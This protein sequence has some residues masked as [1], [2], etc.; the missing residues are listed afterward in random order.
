MFRRL[1]SLSTENPGESRIHPSKHPEATVSPRPD[2]AESEATARATSPVASGQFA[3]TPLELAA[4]KRLFSRWLISPL[5]R[6]RIEHLRPFAEPCRMARAL[7]QVE[8]MVRWLEGGARLPMVALSDSREWMLRFLEHGNAPSAVQISE[9]GRALRISS[10]M[11]R[12]LGELEDMPELTRLAA[13]LPELEGLRETLDGTLDEK[14][15]V[16]SSASPALAR[17]RDEIESGERDIHVRLQRFL[18]SGVQK[19]LQSTQVSWRHDRPVLQVKPEHRRQVPG[20]VHDRS[21]SGQTV[22]VE[23]QTVVEPAN[24]L[25]ELRADER[26][27]IQRVITEL[28]RELHAQSDALLR[29]LEGL[30][31]IDSVHA[32]ARLVREAGFVVPEI[33]SD[34]VIR[35]RDARHPL[36][37]EAVWKQAEDAEQQ[38]AAVEPFDLDLGDPY[39]TLVV[40]GPNTG[41][42]TVVLKAVG[43]IALMGQAGMPVPA[44]SA[45]L[46]CLDGIWADIGD[47]QAIEQSLS[48][49]SSHLVRIH[50]ALE[51]A[52]PNSLVLLDELGAGTDPEE[53]GA[54]GYAILDAL[55]AREVRVIASTHLSKLKDFAYEREGAENGSMAFDPDAL[56]PLYRLEVGIP[57]A[58]Q[59][60]HIAKVVGLDPA[61]LEKAR[62]LLVERDSRLEEIIGQVQRTRRAAEEQRKRAEASARRAVGEERELA[63]KTEEVERRESWIREEAEHFVDEELR[64]ARDLLVDPLKQFVNAPSPYDERARGMLRL[65]E[66]LLQSSSLGR[67]REKYLEEVKKGHMVY[68]P[69]F[70]RRCEVR[71]VDRKRR[72]I[73]V[74][75]GGIRMDLPFDDISWLQPLDS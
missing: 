53:G 47:E 71:K 69:R 74:D 27:E 15:E 66:G 29:T 36:L 58:S 34:C 2:S 72:T 52:T 68:V 41:G 32:R 70:R 40:T 54:L 30:A 49:F 22:F 6:A 18:R 59:A 1:V 62:S 25:S 21:Q 31:W 12:V 38:R 64:T 24:R 16:L 5:A 35:L 42:K 13:L 10:R 56:R 60:L 50:Q 19:Y 51:H 46:P 7:R 44:A 33:A 63:Q 73:A 61:V 45:T 11:Q 9:L 26:S 3:T 14:G 65:V 4:V 67:R 48:T 17:I 57:G 55:H 37:L 20:I 75:V 8:E 39:T 23:P 28:L 43:V